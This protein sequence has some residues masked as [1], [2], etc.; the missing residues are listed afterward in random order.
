MPKHSDKTCPIATS[1]ITYPQWT[2]EGNIST[3]AMRGRQL[4]G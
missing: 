2:T 4:I 3:Y 1:T